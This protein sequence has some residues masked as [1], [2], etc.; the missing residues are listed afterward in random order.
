MSSLYQENSNFHM[1]R[2]VLYNWIILLCLHALLIDMVFCHIHNLSFE[3]VSTAE[4][5]KII[6]QGN[7]FHKNIFVTFLFWCRYIGSLLFIVHWIS[8]IY[9]ILCY[10][11]RITLLRCTLAEVFWRARC[12][13][14]FVFFVLLRYFK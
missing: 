12:S 5:C 3:S 8:I 10:S 1:Q 6:L 11:K 13:L 4:L 2:I 9:I 7:K 14:N